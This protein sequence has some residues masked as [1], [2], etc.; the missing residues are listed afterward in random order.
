MKELFRIIGISKKD[1]KI[2]REFEF[3]STKECAFHNPGF[4]KFRVVGTEVVQEC[5]F[6]GYF[7]ETFIYY[8]VLQEH[9]RETLLEVMKMKELNMKEIEDL[10]FKA[11]Q[12]ETRLA[13]GC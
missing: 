4:H 12:K 7:Q 9:I 3:S 5:N 10:T 6:H 8:K 2:E 13:N 1:K 11:V